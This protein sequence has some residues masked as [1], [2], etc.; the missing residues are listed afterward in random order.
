M[1]GEGGYTRSLVGL[2][3]EGIRDIAS[4]KEENNRGLEMRGQ[5]L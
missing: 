3:G 1:R 2:G 4:K 5:S